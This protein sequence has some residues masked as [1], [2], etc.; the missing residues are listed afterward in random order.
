MAASKIKPRRLYL[1]DGSGYIFRAFHGLP[2]MTRPDGTP[3]NAVYGFSSMM[4]KLLDD[5]RDTSVEELIAV[6]FD[7][8]RK[9]FRN[10][11][12]K[13]YK[14]HR[15]PAPDELIPQ[16]EIIRDATRAFN[17]PAID[18]EGFE[19][20]DLIA[21]YAK[22]AAAAGIDVVVISADKD[23]MQLV[24][25]GVAMHDPMKNRNIGPAEVME[26][27]GVPPNKVID[28]QSLAGDSS[29]NVPGVPGIGIKTAAELINQY[30]DLDTL[31]AKAGEIKQPKR[32]ENLLA[33]ADLARISRQLVTLKDDVPLTVPLESLVWNPPDEDTLVGF[34][35]EQSFKSLMAK[36]SAKLGANAATTSPR[37]AEVVVPKAEA[38]AN[39]A[40][41]RPSAMPAIDRSK[42][43]CIQTNEALQRW[44]DKATQNGWV[45]VDTETTGL[46]PMRDRLVG[47]SLCISA[48]EA[49]YIPLEHGAGIAEQGSLAFDAAPRPKQVI[50]K[51]AVRILGP[52]LRDESVL[53]VG[54][55]IK[56][57]MHILNR[58]G[59]E[60]T[61]V[62]DTIV[63]SYVLDG[64]K[65][66]HG[67]DELSELHL[68]HSTIK[69]SEV[70]GS[71]KNQI[72]FD[73]VPL[74]KA[75]AYAAEDADVTRRFH[76]LLK[77]RLREEH[78]TTVYETL[79]R[80]LIGILADMER[81]GILVDAKVL[82][83]LS[84]DF[85]K[86]MVKL[87]QEIHKLAGE[88][89]NV[90][91][92]K[93]LGEILFERMSLPGG[94]KGKTGA[95]GTG[96]DVLDEL[97]AQGHDLPARVLDWRQLS[98]LKST[99]TDALVETINPE[100][101]RVHTSYSQTV[102]STGRLSSND[103][104]LQNI[105]I[106]TEE[107][108]KIR[109]AFIAPKGKTL[110]SADYSQIELRLVAHVAD[111]KGMKQAFKDGADIHAA[112]ASQ[113]FSV[114]MKDMTSELRRR[115]KAINFGIIYGISGFGL[116]RNL[117]IERSEAQAFINA[118]FTKFPEIRDY[119][120]RAKDEAKKFGYVMTP[121]GRRC[122]VPGI[123]DKNGAVRSFAER[124]AINAP[125]QGGAADIIKRA[126]VRLPDAL[127][128]AKLKA[129]M[130][131]QVHDELI[132]EVPNDE[133]EATTKLVKKVMEQ[134][135]HISVPL[136][137]DTGTGQ[138]WD[139]AH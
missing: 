47:I 81:K 88:E 5:L 10:E 54:H 91:S 105:P 129:D 101:G 93:Q 132:F 43:E 61:P 96:A 23:L 90:G 110:I 103:P 6:I 15:P 126:M 46:D 25:P 92:P 38:V 29:D 1:I 53:K 74:D 57:D 72:T 49:C 131:L 118:Y 80:P 35:A 120:E 89:F 136:V 134:A 73:Q 100:T 45:A 58:V 98:K 82:R 127:K 84:E 71:G 95:Y 102:A 36:V 7:A 32:R 40:T 107:G 122:W 50:L 48:G 139:E 137:V 33:Y 128:K 64:A 9:T 34:L 20:D 14:A 70:C 28:V 116:A 69:F 108:R 4:M 39:I 12:Y 133:V 77:P 113:M 37:L 124:Q 3:V 62:D 76:V 119:M 21:T 138:N 75:T 111:I 130:L 109:T 59:F 66:G 67:M 8:K 22:Q 65:N 97:A 117:G 99:Y 56:F 24:R 135:A 114:P 27:F 106:R 41:S 85:A 60:V 87:E 44:A 11:I 79:E 18:M 31:L 55:N 17:V 112:T 19:A 68:N 115:A 42:Y 123:A 121:F 78:L 83:A 16:F 51:D 104:N 52:M 2:M 86:R 94:K 13:E 26:K 63:I 30:G 125:I